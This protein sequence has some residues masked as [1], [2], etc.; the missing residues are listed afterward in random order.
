MLYRKKK[1]LNGSFE[2]EV[3]AHYTKHRCHI[4]VLVKDNGPV[5]LPRYWRRS[6]NLSLRPAN[7][8]GT[9]LGLSLSYDM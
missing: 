1:I 7:G 5:F 9:G 3:S 2:P 6:F 8:E 4:T